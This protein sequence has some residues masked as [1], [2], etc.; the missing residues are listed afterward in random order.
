VRLQTFAYFGEGLGGLVIFGGVA[1]I[2]RSA[3]RGIRHLHDLHVVIQGQEGS[4]V[5]EPIP[6]LLDRFESLNQR[7]DSLTEHLFSQDERLNDLEMMMRPNGLD[8][9]RLGDIAK[10]IENSLADIKTRLE[11]DGL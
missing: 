4:S 11:H 1:Y 6:S 3:F 5:S 7:M 9:D 2:V 8:T 10:R